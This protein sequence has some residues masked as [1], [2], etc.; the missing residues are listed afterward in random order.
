MAT[1][2]SQTTDSAAAGGNLVAQLTGVPAGALLA[3]CFYERDGGA[4]TSI[5]DSVNGAWSVAVTRA[6][7]AARSGIYFFP[8]SAAGDPT[9]TVQI[10]G[11]SPRDMNFSAWTGIVTASPLDTTNNA[12]NSA[13]TNHTHGSITPS[14]SSLILTCLGL[15]NDHGGITLHSGFSALTVDGGTATPG[16]SVFA[17][18]VAHS[19][20]IT[21]S[22]TSTNAQNSDAVVAA[23]LEAAGGGSSIV[24]PG[25]P[26]RNRR[27][28]GRY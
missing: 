10:A 11:T 7:T 16:R 21:P 2:H 18:K 27:H 13:A 3:V 22:H 12:G 14:G 15:G 9:L 20:A 17:Y 4:I 26:Q 6:I 19:G 28:T 23:F 1:L 24:V 5:A 8:N 25:V